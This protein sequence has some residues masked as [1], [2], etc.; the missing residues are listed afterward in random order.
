MTFEARKARTVVELRRIPFRYASVEHIKRIS[1]AGTVRLCL[2]NTTVA[3]RYGSVLN[4]LSA[5][6]WATLLGPQKTRLHLACKPRVPSLNLV[7]PYSPRPAERDAGYG[8]VRREGGP[9]AILHAT[10]F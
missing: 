6:S 3:T 1:V 7:G 2:H 10:T 8:A 9:L 4:L 5:A